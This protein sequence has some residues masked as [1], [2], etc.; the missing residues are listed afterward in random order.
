MKRYFYSGNP[1]TKKLL[2]S[3]FNLVR[4]EDQIYRD[5][6]LAAL[7]LEPSKINNFHQL[8]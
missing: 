8:R 1:I 6:L 2:N 4:I 3:Q 7:K 5:A